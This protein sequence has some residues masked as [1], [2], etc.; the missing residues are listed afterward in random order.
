MGTILLKFCLLG[1]FSIGLILEMFFGESTAAYTLKSWKK[2]YK[3]N[4]SFALLELNKW[5]TERRNILKQSKMENTN[6][7]KEHFSKCRLDD[8]LLE[9]KSIP[10]HSSLFYENMFPGKSLPEI[11][12]RPKVQIR[13]HVELAEPADDVG[14]RCNRLVALQMKL[15]KAL[16]WFV[17]IAHFRLCVVKWPTSKFSTVRSTELTLGVFIASW[18]TASWK[19][20]TSGLLWWRKTLCISRNYQNYLILLAHVRK[21]RKT[22]QQGQF[23]HKYSHRNLPHTVL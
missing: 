21:L 12:T 8:I 23:H 3:V 14:Y 2:T 6:N 9:T 5:A 17:H 7:R 11:I 13:K 20:S 1:S 22:D 18:T 15:Q 4:V 16:S 19:I 10:V